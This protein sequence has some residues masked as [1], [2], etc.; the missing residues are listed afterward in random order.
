MGKNKKGFTL[1]ELLGM[2]VLLAIVALI[3]FVV[4]DRVMKSGKQDMYDKQ[5]ETIELATK[6]YLTDNLDMLP[7][8]GTVAE[9]PLSVL[10]IAGYLEDDIKDPKT[11]KCFSNEETLITVKRVYDEASYTYKDNYTYTVK[12]NLVDCSL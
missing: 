10:K 9:I 4:I 7:S 3:S 2:L 12:E 5:I 8:D 1:I 6:N 11:G